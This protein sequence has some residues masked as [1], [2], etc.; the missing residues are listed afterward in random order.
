EVAGRMVVMTNWFVSSSGDAAVL[1]KAPVPQEDEGLLVCRRRLGSNQRPPGP[2]A[3][4][5]TTLSYTADGFSF[6]S[7]TSCR[8]RSCCDLWRLR[9]SSTVECGTAFV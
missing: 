3:G 4:R 1:K 2:R 5:S 8:R 6:P 7:S 9:I